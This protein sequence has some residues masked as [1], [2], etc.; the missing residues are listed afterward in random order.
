MSEVKIER[1]NGN[2]RDAAVKYGN[3]LR[4]LA[5]KCPSRASRIIA[6]S[7]LEIMIVST[8]LPIYLGVLA[9][10]AEGKEDGEVAR[11]AGEILS[12]QGLAY[13]NGIASRSMVDSL[14]A[15]ARSENVG[16][17]ESVSAVIQLR[18]REPIFAE[19]GIRD[20]L[21]SIVNGEMGHAEARSAALRVLYKI[22]LEEDS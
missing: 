12:D 22:P 1:P 6:L 4:N 10:I 17:Y 16:P 18:D 21:V 19:P 2:S 8:R 11:L 7:E 13:G 3:L 20:A 9:R 15:I 14:T 5:T